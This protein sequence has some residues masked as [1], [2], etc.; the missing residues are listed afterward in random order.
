[1]VRKIKAKLVLRLRAEGFSRRQIAAQG[2]SRHSVDAV[3]AAADREGVGFEDVIDVSEADVYARLFPGRGEHESVFAQPDW[4]GVHRELAKVGV[5]L[6]LLHNEYRD[7]CQSDGSAVMGYDRFCKTYQQHVLV[8]GLASR[9]GHKS[10]QSVEVDWSG[11]TMQL[12]DPATGARTRV[13]LFVGCLPFSRYAFVEPALDMKQ[14]T[15]LRAHSAMFDWFGG[16]VPRIVPDNLKTGVIKHPA[17]GEVVLNDAYR[18]FAA[19][20]SAAVLPGRVRK[21]KDK[22]SVENTVGNIATWVIAALRGQSFEALAELRGAVY[23]RVRAYNA[24]PFQKRPGSRTGVFETEE[25]MLLRPL[26]AVGFEISRWVYGRRVRKDAHVVFERNFYSVPYAHVGRGVD[27][28]IKSSTLEVFAG[29]QRLT[30]H[31]LAPAGSVNEYRT[32]D[33]D[34]AGGPRYRQWDAVRV[35]E[36]AGRIGENTTTVVNRIFESVPVDE[37]GLDA[38]LAVLRLTRRFSAARVEA[39]A[40]VAL[41]SRVRSPRYAHLRPILDTHQDDPGRR[42]P[43]FEPSGDIAQTEHAEPAGYVRGADYYA[44]SAR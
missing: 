10:G 31:L 35:R 28:R 30:S 44:G 8:T 4:V 19:H 40:Q 41:A 26:P 9:V 36:W 15:W 27:L 29:D 33:T 39:A 5:T 34:L 14:D 38:A 32:H 12:T 42:R 2:M 13:F 1:M 22:A 20:Y 11:P 21:P 24:E 3:I 16:S 6:K 25:K 7:T 18:E 37:Q 17:E 23:E 43:H